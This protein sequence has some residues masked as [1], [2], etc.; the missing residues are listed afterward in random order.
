MSLND[1][2]YILVSPLE[3]TTE[4][5]DAVMQNKSFSCRKDSQGRLVLKYRGYHPIL[6]FGYTTYTHDEIKEI[7]D[8]G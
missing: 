1:Y 6:F 4:R 5:W 8:N 2:K 7:L 3:M